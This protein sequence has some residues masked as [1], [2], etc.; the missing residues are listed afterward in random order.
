M[1]DDAT[2]KG[3]GKERSSE[4]TYGGTATIRPDAT[5]SDVT[6][7]VR[8]ANQDIAGLN[9]DKPHSLRGILNEIDAKE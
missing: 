5:I 8:H 4:V 2:M 3:P 9:D 7:E 1:A 6:E